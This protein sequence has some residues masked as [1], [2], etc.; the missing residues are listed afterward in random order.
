MRR[1]LL[2]LG[3]GCATLAVA[4]AAVAGTRGDD[5]AP[6][7]AAGT[8]TGTA[9]VERRTLVERQSADGRLGYAGSRKVL[10]RLSG[11]ITWLPSSGARIGRGQRLF[12]V[13]GRPVV[14]MYGRRPAY[15]RMARGIAGGEDVRQL[16]R[17]LVALGFDSGRAITVD[18]RFDAATAAAVR[19]WRRSLGLPAGDAVELGRVVFMPGR[20]RVTEVAA[21][22]GDV[23]GGGGGSDADAG[24]GAEGGGGGAASEVLTT[25]STRQVVTLE[26]DAGDA[27]VAREGQRVD[28]ELPDATRV[29]GRVARVG[30]VATTS[31]DDGG[32]TGA[33]GGDDDEAKITV[34]VTLRGKPRGAR[35]DQAPVSVQLTRVTR[36][37]VLTVPVTAL[38]AQRGGGYAVQVR[39]AGGT[40]LVAVTTG[41]FADGLVEVRG[42]GL[43][44]GQR[45]AVP[46]A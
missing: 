34:V 30:T 38:L 36:R 39:T 9:K 8:A 35:L 45:V 26:L 5:D 1:R 33:G 37:N 25:T 10:N 20:R 18:R 17:N 7:A 6:P 32:E 24:A 28:V 21:S 13:D 43:R 23:A 31:G 29:R 15:R 22:L 16:E 3:A 19:R 40:R 14:L 42:R 44:A 2:M 27:A 12:E 46:A 41:L 11:T 4:A